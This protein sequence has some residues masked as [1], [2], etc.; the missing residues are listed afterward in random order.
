VQRTH[1]LLA[2]SNACRCP[3]F[4]QYLS[5]VCPAFVQ[6]LSSNHMQLATPGLGVEP[7]D[8]VGKHV[9]SFGRL[10]RPKTPPHHTHLQGCAN[11]AP[12]FA[13]LVNTCLPSYYKSHANPRRHW[14]SVFTFVIALRAEGAAKR[15]TPASSL[16]LRNLLRHR[17]SIFL[18]LVKRP[19]R[20]EV[21][22]GAGKCNQ[23]RRHE[24]YDCPGI[25]IP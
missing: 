9:R 1:P 18:S 20:E 2:D 5:S 11:P 19:L 17:S 7:T 4:V 21:G 3:V 24:S 12:A 23:P 8:S 14:V 6:Y 13:F 25:N 15:T 10:Y 16:E 22:Y